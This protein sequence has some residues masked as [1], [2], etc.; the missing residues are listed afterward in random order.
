MKTVFR[1][2]LALIA[3][4]SITATVQAADFETS[5]D[6]LAAYDWSGSYFGV[7]F[8]G[9]VDGTAAGAI[10]G[11]AG[12]IGLD[13]ILGG[14]MSGYNF[15]SGNIV[16]GI[17]SDFAFTD[18]KGSATAGAFTGRVS[19][20]TL[21]TTRAR[22]GIAHDRFLPYVTGGLAL[23]TADFSVDGVGSDN[24]EWFVGYT[25]GGGVE[26]AINDSWAARVEY[27]YVDP[28]SEGISI[29]GNTARASLDDI[30]IVRAGVSLKTGF[31]WD[32]L[33]GQ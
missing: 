3:L 10:P 27:Q 32:A 20:D 25:L 11:S 33:L 18:I 24:N 19:I 28:G 23:A 12:E 30:H 14:T 1:S 31:I 13:G 16:F 21:S 15:Q 7:K 2:G 22:I 4:L 8:G 6:P 9:A 17:D 26:W 5:A 29:G